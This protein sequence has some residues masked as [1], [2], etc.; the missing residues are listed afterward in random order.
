MKGKYKTYST[1]CLNCDRDIVENGKK[2][3]VCGWKHK[4]RRNPK[5]TMDDILKEEDLTNKN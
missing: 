5:P 4:G 2:C 3:R 1:Y